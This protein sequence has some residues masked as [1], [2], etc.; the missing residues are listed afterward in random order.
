MNWRDLKIGAKLGL[1]F[2]AIMLTFTILGTF[3]LFNF[4]SIGNKAESLAEES[5]PLTEVAN[6]IAFTAQKAM[7]AQRGYRY[8][9]DEKFL[10]EGEE[11]LKNL[12]QLL[13]EADVLI[14]K[15]H[16]VRKI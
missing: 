14:Q 13:A 9:E 12:R 2:G 15:T 7:Y 8:T 10:N 3:I 4:F 11:H 6:K 16:G 1:S 5:I